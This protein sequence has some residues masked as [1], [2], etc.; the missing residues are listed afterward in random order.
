[1]TSRYELNT[2]QWRKMEEILTGILDC[3]AMRRDNRRFVNGVCWVL[4]SGAR[5]CDMPPRYGKWKIVHQRFLRWAEQGIWD[6][7]FAMLTKDRDN[8]YVM[9][10]STIIRAHQQAATSKKNTQTRLWGV[11]EEG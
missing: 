7:M 1:M 11:P 6:A 4:R 5:W 3:R 10:D 9:I 2:A 8:E